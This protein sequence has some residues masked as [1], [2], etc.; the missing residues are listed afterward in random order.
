MRTL[1]L[2][3]EHVHA[4]NFTLRPFSSVHGILPCTR[5][6]CEIPGWKVLEAHHGGRESIV[7]S[8]CSNVSRRGVCRSGSSLL[9][10]PVSCVH[11]TSESV[12]SRDARCSAWRYHSLRFH[13]ESA[14]ATALGNQKAEGGAEIDGGHPVAALH[15][16]PDIAGVAGPVG[17]VGP[18]GPPGRL[19]GELCATLAKFRVLVS[20][21]V[22]KF[23][24]IPRNS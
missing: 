1:P 6:V 9:R 24:G 20:V 2:G 18:V 11:A 3:A 15:P 19:N 7:P 16:P 8:G 14:P 13:V 10:V 21:T 4:V 17:P 23:P 12:G 22:G 5:P